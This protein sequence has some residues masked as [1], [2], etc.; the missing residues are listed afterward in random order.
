MSDMLQRTGDGPAGEPN[1]IPVELSARPRSVDG[2]RVLG[3]VPWQAGRRRAQGDRPDDT[4]MVWPH[5]LV[6]HGVAAMATLLVVMVI[7]V[8]FDAPLQSI[9]NP[10]SRRTR[11]R[12]RGTS[13]RSRNCSRCSTRPWPGSSCP[14]RS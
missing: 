1:G 7:A 8:L 14:A 4:V 13:W 5:L 6:R 9:A 12:R 2:K 10:R 11:R 3:V